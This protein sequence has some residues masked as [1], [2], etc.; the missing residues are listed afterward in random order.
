M[1]LIPGHMTLQKT[2]QKGNVIRQKGRTTR[3]EGN[4]RP[5]TSSLIPRITGATRRLS[6]GRSP[7]TSHPPWQLH[8]PMIQTLTTRRPPSRAGHAPGNNTKAEGP[9]DEAEGSNM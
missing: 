2:G 8:L 3:Q 9:Y 5:N 7:K 4:V 1:T 6:G